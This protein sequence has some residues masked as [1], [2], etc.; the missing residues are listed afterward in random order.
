[1]AET[2]WQ[3]SFVPYLVP[4]GLNKGLALKLQGQAFLPASRSIAFT[5]SAW[6]LVGGYPEE[7]V[8]GGEDLKFAD[9]LYKNPE[10]NIIFEPEALVD[11]PVPLTLTAFAKD[12]I[13]HTRGNFE[14]GYW[15]HI[16]RNLS[17]VARWTVMV[18]W[19]WVIPVYLIWGIRG[20]GGVKVIRGIVVRAVADAAVVYGTVI[21]IIDEWVIKTAIT[22]FGWMTLL[23][24]ASRE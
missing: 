18:V 20:I 23:R 21:G 6:E 5:K 15:P 7:P 24:I 12:I 4:A 19:P 16:Y 10:V 11:W 22:G 9:N 8:S 2:P 3:K 1:M 13:K 14:A 17:V